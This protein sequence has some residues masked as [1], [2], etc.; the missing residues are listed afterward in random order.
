MDVRWLR[1]PD[2][3]PAGGSA[4]L[5]ATGARLRALRPGTLVMV[6]GLA[7]GAMPDLAAELTT[8]LR[9]VALVHHPLGLETGLDPATAAA[10]LDRE[11]RA[12][13]HA[14]RIV[15]T[16]AVTAATLSGELGVPPEQ[17][18]VAMPGTDPAPLARG[19]P[20]PTP[21][22]L[23]VGSVI[24]RKDFATLIR[25]CSRLTDLPWD[26]RIV[27]SLERDPD[28]TARV[29]A[30]I[31]AH[32]LAERV[33]LTGELSAEALSAAY[34]R[35]DLVVSSSRYEGFGMALA[36]ALARGLPIVAADGGAVGS[37][38]PAEAA[39]LVEP[40]SVDALATALRRLLGDPPRLDALRAGARR[41]RD[42]LVRWSDT[43]AVVAA[44]LKE[45]GR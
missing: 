9:L 16:S 37:W 35:A 26:L 13:R 27:G 20:G 33:I 21:A 41:A 12:L 24:P 15:V 45:V 38:L 42:R 8:R 40:G 2:G 39:V 10:W 44:A 25:A 4:T 14:R 29:R 22:L 30:S 28:E 32:G 19:G 3:F 1:L 36:E 34:H 31:T 7:F 43:A 17:I 11:R 5:A 6:D 23:A 18:T